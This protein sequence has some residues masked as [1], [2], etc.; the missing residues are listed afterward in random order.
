MAAKPLGGYA[1]L[2]YGVHIMVRALESVS[3][4]LE[5][6]RLSGRITGNQE[7]KEPTGCIR[8]LQR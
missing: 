3:F 4:D 2:T 6:L 7:M 8:S 5:K 1:F